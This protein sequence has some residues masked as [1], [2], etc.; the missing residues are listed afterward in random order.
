MKCRFDMSGEGTRETVAPI[1]NP[2]GGSGAGQRQ[3]PG[4]PEREK[5]RLGDGEFD[6]PPIWAQKPDLIGP[7]PDLDDTFAGKGLDAGGYGLGGTTTGGQPR[8]PAVSDAYSIMT[9]SNAL[10]GSEDVPQKRGRSGRVKGARKGKKKQQAPEVQLP[11]GAIEGLPPDLGSASFSFG[12]QESDYRAPALDPG[13]AG[14]SGAGRGGASRGQPAGHGQPPGGLI[15]Q[16]S[17]RPG[18]RGPASVGGY[19][20]EPGER[21]APPG[22]AY[23][24]RSG[25]Q[26]AAHG[27]S[28]GVEFSGGAAGLPEQGRVPPV[29]RPI[30]KQEAVAAGQ[31]VRRGMPPVSIPAFLSVEKLR[32]LITAR[33]VVSLFGG[34]VV[35]LALAYLLFGGGYF[36]SDAGG[37]LESAQKAMRA[38]GSV[39]VEAEILLQTQKAGSFT[40]AVSADVSKDRDLRAAYAQ[41]LYNPG[42]EYVTTGGKTYVRRNAGA[43]EVSTDSSNPDLTSSAMFAG[44]SGPMLVNK[45]V[46]DGVEC[47]HVAF[48]SSPDYIKSLFP[49]V[50]VTES[51]RVYT[52]IWIDPQ[53]KTVRHARITACNLETRELGRF[54]CHVELSFSNFGAPLEIAPPA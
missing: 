47:D 36:S 20:G 33:A 32:G 31:K 45:E 37:L 43:W 23:P 50:D 7:P 4:G 18:A 22:E 34:V 40:T 54:N 14:A 2:L 52:E 35:L 46:I 29:R 42:L 38:A 41:T 13:A 39:H 49:G 21:G 15:E 44:A 24:A 6:E 28:S 8:G 10:M 27:P 30:P 19:A 11:P 53:Q 26:T 25:M 1:G 16:A 9:S 12:M 48:E 3:P 17:P 51:T 5:P